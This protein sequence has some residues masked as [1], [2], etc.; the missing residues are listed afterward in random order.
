LSHSFNPVTVITSK[1]MPIYA[2]GFA[3]RI[4]L[5]YRLPH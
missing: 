5:Q 2:F 4:L 3:I 1:Y